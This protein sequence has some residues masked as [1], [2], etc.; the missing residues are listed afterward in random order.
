MRFIPFQ[1]RA[2]LKSRFLFEIPVPAFC[3]PQRGGRC[4][5]TPKLHVPKP[6]RGDR[7]TASQ[8]RNTKNSFSNDQ[9]W[10]WH[11]LFKQ[12]LRRIFLPCSP[13]RR[14]PLSEYLNNPLSFILNL[15]IPTIKVRIKPASIPTPYFPQIY[16]VRV[17]DN[18]L[19]QW[20]FRD[21]PD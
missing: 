15:L 20:H 7:R 2:C 13:L 18:L 16:L 11:L 21:R 6:Q 10:H 12:V 8:G 3:K 5:V 9:K 19:N 1:L 14:R 4:V 17:M